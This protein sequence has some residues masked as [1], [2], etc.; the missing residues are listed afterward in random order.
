ME[1]AITV[2]VLGV[3]ALA[4]LFFVA[5]RM[6]RLAVRLTLGF[7]LILILIAGALFWWWSGMGNPLEQNSNRTQAPARRTS[8]R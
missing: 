3:A 4:V 1:I 2:A 5:R 6:L 7:L 8:S